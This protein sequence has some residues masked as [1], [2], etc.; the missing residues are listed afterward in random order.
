MFGRLGLDLAREHQPHLV[1]LDLHLPDLGGERVLAELRADEATRDIPVVILS[2]DATRDRAQF[3]AAGAQAY[4]TKPIDLRRLL[5]VL[6]QF[7]AEA[8]LGEPSL[9]LAD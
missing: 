6:D 9:R 4:L 8:P 5:E 3:L 7:L 1:L 2:A